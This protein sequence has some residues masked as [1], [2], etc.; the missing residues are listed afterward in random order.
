MSIDVHD[1]DKA[2]VQPLRQALH[3]YDPGTVRAALQRTFAKEARVRLA[4]PFEDLDGPE[5]LYGSAFA[6]LHAGR[7]GSLI[8]SIRPGRL[9]AMYW[10]VGGDRVSNGCLR[11]LAD[12]ESLPAADPAA[13]CLPLTHGMRRVRCP[14]PH[15]R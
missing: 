6:P 2:L 4:C 15:I 1:L 12:A 11:P 8:E 3:D 7:R 9:A 5:G 13:G 10:N 14:P